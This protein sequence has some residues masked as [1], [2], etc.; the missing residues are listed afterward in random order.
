MPNK[1]GDV[2]PY[3]RGM[4]QQPVPSYGGVSVRCQWMLR[5]L[6]KHNAWNDFGEGIAIDIPIKCVQNF[7]PTGEMQGFSQ[8][9]GNTPAVP[10][11][12]YVQGQYNHEAPQK[13]GKGQ[14]YDAVG[15]VQQ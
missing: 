7:I 14:Q 4:L 12:E 1:Q 3:Q 15:Q 2:T 11:E 9:L 6:H 5:V 13:E 8:Q 10:Q